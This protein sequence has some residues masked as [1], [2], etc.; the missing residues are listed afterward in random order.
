MAL[1]VYNT[2]SRRKE[3]FE[4]IDPGWVR[5]YV[6]G[7]TVYDKA[8]IGHAMSSIVFDVI[9]RYLEHRGYQVRYVMNYTD[10]E[11]KIIA[12]A[13]TLGA[14]PMRLAEGYIAEYEQHLLD[15][16]ILPASAYP[17]ASQEIGAILEM[18]QGLIDKGFAYVVEGDVYFRVARDEDYGRLSGRRQEDMLA[19][20]RPEVD[21]RKQSAGDFALWKAAKPGE[22]AW[23]SPWG[24]GRPGWHIE[25]SAM[26]RHHLGDQIDVHGGGNDLL[27][28]HHENEIAQSESLTGKPFARYWIHNGM[29]QLAGEKMSKSLGNLVTVEAFLKE[30]EGDALRMLILNSSYRSPLTF[31]E[32]VVEQAE[33][34]LERL[35]GALRPASP[36]AAPVSQ[37]EA[38]LAAQAETTRRGFEQAMDD[39]FNTPG[40]LSHLFELVRAINQARDAGASVEALGSAQAILRQLAGVLGLRLEVEP[41]RAREAAPFIDLL[42]EIREEL[43][44]AKQW[45]LADRIRDRLQ[46][47][48]VVLEDGRSGTSWRVG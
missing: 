2:L 45:P 11:D 8:H 48:G 17:R 5:M 44:Q 38:D 28:P 35:R 37:V 4:T 25:C 7:P 10:V 43:R 29:M 13:K 9:R 22:P 47:M 42:V 24:L 34:A 39:D 20:V 18:V 21:E 46:Q 19:G 6:C 33:R 27:F 12:R 30:H 16:N 14:D 40:A 1:M 31:T 3:P 15:L 41:R 26:I 23:D 32:T 36:S